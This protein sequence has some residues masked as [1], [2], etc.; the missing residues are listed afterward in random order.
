MTKFKLAKISESQILEAA[1]SW[2]VLYKQGDANTIATVGES[3]LSDDEA[4]VRLLY[5]AH[6]AMRGQVYLNDKYQV[7]RNEISNGM[8]HLSIKLINKS[9]EHDWREYQ[10]IKNELIGEE[11][12]AMEIYPAESRLVDAANQFHIWG[13][14]D[15]IY[16]IPVG[17]QERLVLERSI[18]GSHQRPF[19]KSCK[20]QS[21]IK[22]R[23]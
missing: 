3:D 2:L 1:R 10:Q 14:L 17:F 6:E 16:R 20:N 18:A 22:S 4:L 21:L 15:P 8:V 12:E 7:I 9:H 11:C 19:K 23:R 5:F 13:W